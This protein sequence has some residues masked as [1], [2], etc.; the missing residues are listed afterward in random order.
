MMD[1]VTYAIQK[2][3][4][5]DLPNTVQLLE[6]NPSYT[7][8]TPAEAADGIE[9]IVDCYRK[10]TGAIPRNS[11]D[12]KRPYLHHLPWNHSTKNLARLG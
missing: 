4:I 7:N 6:L 12:L 1:K 3:F 10:H 11:R 8:I 2:N 9:A 5:N